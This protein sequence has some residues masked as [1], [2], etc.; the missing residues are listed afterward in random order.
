M[1]S[2]FHNSV[3]TIQENVAQTRKSISHNTSACV[4][5]A[6]AQ[7]SSVRE[8]GSESSE[9]IGV[10]KKKVLNHEL[11]DDVPTSETPKKRNYSVPSSWPLTRSHEEILGQLNK[12]PLSNVDVNLAAQTPGALSRMRHVYVEEPV[13]L[14]IP[15]EKKTVTPTF[16]KDLALDKA[17]SE[18]RENANAFKSRIA[19]PSRKR[20]LGHQLT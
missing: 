17:P 2:T 8:F 5:N 19:A 20:V 3:S 4:T 14:E 16:E 6:D 15:L 9:L 13:A 7:I 10:L 1:A 12:M 11:L 18:G